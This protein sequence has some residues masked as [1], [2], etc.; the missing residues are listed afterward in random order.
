MTHLIAIKLGSSHTSIFKQG[1]GIVLYEPSLVSY[2][3]TGRNKVIKAVG[4]RA[5]RITGRSSDDVTT[6]SPI[7]G[8]NQ[9]LRTCNCNA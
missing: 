3:G 2:S 9:R 1:D 4:T 5:K 7:L 8:D 6:I